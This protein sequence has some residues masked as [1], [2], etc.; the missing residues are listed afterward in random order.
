[1]ASSA[2]DQT[3]RDWITELSKKDYML[4]AQA[5]ADTWCDSAAQLAIAEKLADRLA[6]ENPS[7]DKLR[8]L[9]ACGVA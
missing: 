9:A 7:F 2:G 3:K 6:D 8:F 4:I 5:I 1:L